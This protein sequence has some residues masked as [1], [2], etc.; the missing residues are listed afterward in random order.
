MKEN[1][2][3]SVPDKI[4]HKMTGLFLQLRVEWDHQREGV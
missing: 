3:Q 1:Y 2:D 4:E